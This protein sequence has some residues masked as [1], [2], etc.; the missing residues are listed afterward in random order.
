MDRFE[1]FMAFY[2]L[3]LGLGVAELLAGFA[4][5]LRERD[6]PKLGLLTPLVGVIILTEMVAN[7]I[8]AWVKFQ[9][10]QITLP[11]LAVPMLIG[12]LYFVVAVIL[13]PRDFSEWPSLEQYF[14]QRRRWIVGL[15]I[16]ANLLIISLEITRLE[17]T[18]TGGREGDPWGFLAGNIWLLASY[19]VL[20][21]SRKQWLSV[22]AGL[23]VLSFYSYYYGIVLL[24]TTA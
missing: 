21:L 3:L 5:I 18:I 17:R 22:V 23:S 13:L 8:D 24:G 14:E 7:F 11:G 2:G 9:D 12:L 6:R 4:N 20:L 1:F 19:I 16:A 10:I 15:L